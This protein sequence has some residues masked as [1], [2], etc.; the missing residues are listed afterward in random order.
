MK[1]IP[2][3]HDD[4]PTSE[5]LKAWPHLHSIEL[6]DIDAD[7]G[8]MIGNNVAAATWNRGVSFTDG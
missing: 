8:L 7:I 1:K 2:V 6:Q 4:I 3:S 5:D